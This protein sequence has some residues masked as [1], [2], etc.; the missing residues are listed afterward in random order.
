MAFR[1]VFGNNDS[2]EVMVL[3]Y[4]LYTSFALFTSFNIDVLHLIIVI[5]LCFNF[6]SAIL[7][8][9]AKIELQDVFEDDC[10]RGEII[11]FRRTL[12]I[13]RERVLSTKD[14]SFYF[15]VF[16]LFGYFCNFEFNS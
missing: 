5:Y 11:S 6:L 3:D 8:I 1:W 9:G 7:L 2:R 4:N 12:L 10:F 15:I 16:Y 14:C 13:R